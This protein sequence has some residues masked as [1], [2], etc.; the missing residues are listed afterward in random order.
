MNV[1]EKLLEVNERLKQ[2]KSEH[3]KEIEASPYAEIDIDVA[4]GSIEDAAKYLTRLNDRKK[5]H[6]ENQKSAS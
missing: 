4:V 3:L 6:E 2:I 5:N 1:A